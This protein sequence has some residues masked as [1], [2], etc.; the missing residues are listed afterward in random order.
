MIKDKDIICFGPGDWWGMNPSCATHIMNILS[1]QNRILY[2]NPISSDLLG[3]RDKKGVLPRIVRKLK[4]VLKFIKNPKPDL[5]VVS[6]IFLPLQGNPV[7]DR[8]NNMLVTMQLKLLLSFF[9]MKQPLLWIENIRAADFIKCCE[10]SL[11]IY[12]VSDL[13]EECSYT[14]NKEKLQSLEKAASQMSD[15]IVCV[16]RQ[17]YEAKKTTR[18]NVHYLPHG[19]DFDLFRKAI[20]N[21][22][23]YKSI[24]GVSSPI[25]G[26]F[27]TLTAQNDIELL[28]YC[29][30]TLKHISFVFAGQITGGDY[31]KL[32]GLPNAMFLGKVAYKEIPKLCGAFDL[33]LLPWK[34]NQWIKSCNPL[35]LFEYMASGKPIVS[36]LINEVVINF[37]DVVS[38]ASTKE[39]F[40]NAIT[41][42]L[43]NDNEQRRNKRIAIAKKYSWPNMIEVLSDLIQQKLFNN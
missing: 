19:V 18:D 16:S 40:C 29:V 5:Y 33:C 34:M 27:G 12:H 42:E 7:I 23:S 38:T 26:Y 36:V 28:E 2:I 20:E 32:L 1:T 10:W 24:I 13:F 41:W 11:V 6:L 30:T 35:K 8:I 21:K 9:K 14:R 17:L 25:A 4:S 43:E 39:E 22:E 3:M 15:L 37:A 31:S